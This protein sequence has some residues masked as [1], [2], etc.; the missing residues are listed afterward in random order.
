LGDRNTF[1]I[2][3]ARVCDNC[4]DKI[5]PIRTWFKLNSINCE[6]KALV[7][8]FFMANEDKKKFLSEV[9]WETTREEVVEV[10]VGVRRY[11]R[12]I[13]KSFSVIKRYRNYLLE[14]KV[15]FKGVNSLTS[16]I[17]WNFNGMPL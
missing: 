6:G 14:S 1:W 5:V 3:R 17:E 8:F 2:A 4:E 9:V 16:E 11:E 13:K 12:R 10:V 15:N 7:S